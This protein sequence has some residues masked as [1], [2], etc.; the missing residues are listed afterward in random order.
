MIAPKYRLGWWSAG[1][2]ALALLSG[3]WADGPSVYAASCVTG[4]HSGTLTVSQ[5]WCPEHNPH[6]LNG[7]VSVPDGITLTLRPGVIV[8]AY[9]STY[10]YVAG[11]LTAIGTSAEPV[12]LTS[13]ADSGP[14]QWGGIFLHNGE[15]DLRHVTIRYTGQSSFWSSRAAIHVMYS[16]L[17]LENS[18]V[19]DSAY[20]GGTDYGVLVCC[21]SAASS[22]VI[23]NTLFAN[24]GDSAADYAAYTDN[25]LNPITVTSSVFQNNAG[26]PI[27]TAAEVVHQITGSMFS[28]NGFNRILLWGY[29]FADQ[30]RLT[31]QTGLEAY[32]FKESL[33]V[34]AGRTLFIDPGVMVMA[35]NDTNI[36][37]NGHLEAIGTP[38]QPITFTS[39]TNTG[40]GQWGH[41][42][43]QEGSADL[44]YVTIRYGG[45]LISGNT[46]AGAL[47]LQSSAGTKHFNLDHV[48]VRDNAY[49]SAA[50][51]ALRV[52]GGTV[53]MNAT[54]VISNGNTPGDYGIYIHDGVVTATHSL[55]QNN[56]GR[57]VHIAGGRLRMTCGT[58]SG[59]GEDGIRVAGGSGST[60]IGAGIYGNAGM[61]LNNTTAQTVTAAYNW[62][63]HASGPGGVG[64]GSGDEVSANV[65]YAPWLSAEGC[66]TGLFIAKTAED[67]NGAPLYAG[68]L[69]R[70]TIQVTNA[71]GIAQT[72]LLVTDTLPPGVT[73]VS[74]SPSGDT[75]PNPLTW[76]A[77]AL[78]P[79]A[80]WTATVTVTVNSNV[81]MIG[82]NVAQA[83]SEQQATIQTEAVLPPGGGVVFQR[84]FLALVIRQ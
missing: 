56:A 42:Y 41:V 63:G 20:A 5:D 28:G 77:G 27:H 64:T 66:F 21:S 58:V 69:V 65:I 72:G 32:E 23:S 4:P 48:T 26:Y 12:L 10:L 39:A 61:G 79:G 14:G 31:S 33:S 51:Y 16:A 80:W 6:I 84:T 62:W 34:P 49:S 52:S 53:T 22:A 46:I 59:N 35:R 68:D 60:F 55:A 17:N 38:G 8:K 29:S 37:I 2:L 9:G 81:A 24:L 54:S 3:E 50:D 70:Y 78:A 57:G 40:P 45:Q 83:G 67:V 44:R 7:T 71:G 30:A 73:F 11:A 19:R 76:T 36:R 82:G 25:G 18:V 47:L 15:A 43:I 13:A 74:A 75:G 1:L